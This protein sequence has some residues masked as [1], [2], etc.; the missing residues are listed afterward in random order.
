MSKKPEKCVFILSE[1]LAPGVA[2]NC[3][4]LLGSS[5][6]SHF[7]ELIGD[8]YKDADGVFHLGLLSLPIIILKAT[9]DELIQ[10]RHN[11]LE[12]EKTQCIDLSNISQEA[13]KYSELTEAASKT[14]FSAFKYRALT[15]FGDSEEINDLTRGLKLY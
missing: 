14:R 8:N 7:P 5:L 10:I 1:G 4:A 9:E 3:T 2:L 11:A 12:L 6:G 13:K 15:L